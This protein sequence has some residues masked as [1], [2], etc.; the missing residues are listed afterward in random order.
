M[1][2]YIYSLVNIQ[3]TMEHHHFFMG[4]LAISMAIFSGCVKLPEGIPIDHA[5]G[6]FVSEKQGQTGLIRKYD[7]VRHLDNWVS[8][9]DFNLMA[10]DFLFSNANLLSLVSY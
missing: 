3:K 4:K 10:M 8:I 7:V 6:W 1:R 5:S 9:H 2:Y